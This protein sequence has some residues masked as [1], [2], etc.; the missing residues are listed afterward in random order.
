MD[1]ITG[2]N[3]DQMVMMDFESEVG[4]DSWARIVDMFVDILPL[5]TWRYVPKTGSLP[6]PRQRNIHRSTTA[7]TQWSISGTIK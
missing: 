4:P 5:S 6:S 3:R 7:F 2:F 1:F